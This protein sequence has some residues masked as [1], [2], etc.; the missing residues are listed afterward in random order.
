[1][2]IGTLLAIAH[3]VADSLGSGC[4][5]LI[6]VYEMNIFGEARRSPG[7][8]I[9]VDFLAGK[10]TQGRVSPALAAAIAKYRDVLPHLCSRSGASVEDFRTLTAS[11]SS[12]TIHRRII[13]AVRDK[14]GRCSVD[15]YVG[16]PAK[17]IK[18]LDAYGRIR[19][20]RARTRIMKLI[21]K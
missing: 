15:E 17:R 10:A 8:S 20:R 11:Y 3:N 16:T 1:M 13:V 21:P 9:C 6:G 7:A 12:D 14:R 4:G 18:V 19:T 5:L 2:K